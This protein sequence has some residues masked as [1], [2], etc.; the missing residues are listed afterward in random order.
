MPIRLE[1]LTLEGTTNLRFALDLSRLTEFTYV[2]CTRNESTTPFVRT[3]VEHARLTDLSLPSCV[4]PRHFTPKKRARREDWFLESV[5]LN[6][7]SSGPEED[8]R[9]QESFPIPSLEQL[10]LYVDARSPGQ[11]YLID[12]LEKVMAGGQLEEIQLRSA[13]VEDLSDRVGWDKQVV[14]WAKRGVKVWFNSD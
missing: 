6:T 8:R 7:I 13:R 9:I 11:E 10:I 12:H 3:I 1:S 2:D 4:F 14:E 5:T